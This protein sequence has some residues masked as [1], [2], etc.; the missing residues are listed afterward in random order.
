MTH[1]RRQSIRLKGYNYSQPGAYFVT[2][3]TRKRE[4]LF[5]QIINGVMH[6]NEFGD[7]ATEEWLQSSEIRHEIQLDIFMVMPNHIH[8]IVIITNN[9]DSD[10]VGATG[11]SPL[12]TGS[13]KAYGPAKRSLGSFIAGYKSQVTKRVNLL[14]RSPGIPVWQRNYYEHIIRH[15]DEMN[16]LRNYI[17]TN[18]IGWESDKYHPTHAKKIG[19]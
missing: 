13:K 10:I 5:G 4:C 14:R 17:A 8:G 15:D 9:K 18:P 1:H 7:I 19:G 11:R 6:L 3:C 16:Q 2:I 12:H